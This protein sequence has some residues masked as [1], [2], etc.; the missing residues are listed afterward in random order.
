[1]TTAPPLAPTATPRTYRRRLG[2]P[3]S[4]AELS[5][6]LDRMRAAD[7]PGVCVPL[8]LST[9]PDGSVE[10]IEPAAPGRDLAALLGERG[11]LATAEV[12]W[13]GIEA[14]RALAGLH[15]AGLAH[16]DVSPHSVVVGAGEVTLVNALAATADGVADTAGTAGT[17][18]TAG[19]SAPERAVSASSAADVYSLGRVLLAAAGETTDERLLAWIE[20]LTRPDPA[21]RPSATQ[22]ARALEQCVPP[23]PLSA[24][25]A[26]AAAAMRR[27]VGGLSGGAPEPRAVNATQAGVAWR[28]RALVAS[29]VARTG[30]AARAAVEGSRGLVSRAWATVRRAD[31]ADRAEERTE[32]LPEAR[33]W[34]VRRGLVRAAWV[35]AAALGA[36][37]LAVAGVAV[38]RALA[39]VPQPHYE[40]GL[41]VSVRLLADSPASAAAELTRA[42]FRALENSDAAALAA[43]TVPDSPAAAGDASMVRLLAAGDV[44][45]DGL[46]VSVESTHA[47]AAQGRSATVEIVYVVSAHRAVEGGVAS[48]FAEQR[49]SAALDLVWGTTGWKVTRVR[50]S[51]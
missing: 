15:V 8:E 3:G 22:V 40:P 30:T 47:V 18:G 26:D 51:P 43:L 42:R 46:E 14:A 45:F 11:A 24:D 35:V 5:A 10:A 12:V 9:A 41:P 1:M 49:Y 25:F 28:G 37:V 38:A 44:T 31:G 17:P 33:W 2:G 19:F 7:L 27:A 4:L 32:P 13:L 50:P 36:C 48:D 21:Q 20:P 16:G 39:P 29:L 23:R 6:R 34:R